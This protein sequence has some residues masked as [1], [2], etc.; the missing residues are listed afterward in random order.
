MCDKC[1]NGKMKSVDFENTE[2]KE[3]DK[4]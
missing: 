3:K 2:F 4:P 1:I